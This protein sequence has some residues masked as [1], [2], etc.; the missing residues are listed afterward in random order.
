MIDDITF[1]SYRND[2]LLLCFTIFFSGYIMGSSSI[3]YSAV[4]LDASSRALLLS[5][6]SA[7]IPTG[8]VLKAD[9]MTITVGPLVHP[10]GK[11]DLSAQYPKGSPFSLNVHA[12]RTGDRAVAVEVALPETYTTRNA[13]AHI[14]IAINAE[15]GAK[16]RESN[17]LTEATS[18]PL[19]P[20][21]LT[22]TIQEIPH[23]K[24][25]KPSAP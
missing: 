10:K 4:V 15:Q 2:L 6:V 24:V 21:L 9:H 14:T 25:V 22:G 8:W 13:Y 5:K 16:A 17:D 23:Q 19:E 3:S 1:F 7:F 12:I 11:W 18:Q 20:F